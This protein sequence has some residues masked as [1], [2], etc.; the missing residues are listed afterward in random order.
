MFKSPATKETHERSETVQYAPAG[1]LNYGFVAS[2]SSFARLTML[3]PGFEP[4]S[5]PILELL[6]SVAPER[7]ESLAG[8]DYRSDELFF[9][10]VL[11]NLSVGCAES[12]EGVSR[13]CAG[14]AVTA[15]WPD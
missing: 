10:F 15:P 8:L 2:R 11:L 4:G 5:Q 14:T 12:S 1:K 9:L 7:A 6:L 13:G 3:P